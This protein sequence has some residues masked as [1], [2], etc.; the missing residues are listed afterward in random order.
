MG[1]SFRRTRRQAARARRRAIVV[2]G[3][4]VAALLQA[5][6]RLG[7]R[8]ASALPVVEAGSLRLIGLVS[9]SHILAAYERAL[10]GHG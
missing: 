7:V 5:T 3:R 1:P 10:S 2:V 4:P 8:G 6:R 9:R